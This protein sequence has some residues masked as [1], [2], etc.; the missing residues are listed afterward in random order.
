MFI[1]SQ[2]SMIKQV[3]RSLQ[4]GAII[5]LSFLLGLL[6]GSTFVWDRKNGARQEKLEARQI[7]MESL[8]RARAKKIRTENFRKMNR[9]TKRLSPKA[10]K[11]PTGLSQT[12]IRL[13]CRIPQVPS[14]DMVRQNIFSKNIGKGRARDWV[15]L[16]SRKLISQI[17][18]FWDGNYSNPTRF[19]R[20]QPDS[21][22]VQSGMGF[23]HLVTPASPTR[24]R[25]KAMQYGLV[26][27]LKFR[28]WGIEDSFVG[29]ASSIF[30]LHRD[31]WKDLPGAD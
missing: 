1:V 13:K 12:L 30:Y 25:K 7:Y 24:M 27:S 4:P 23:S 5:L 15:V 16:C 26:K 22:Y 19:E 18:I 6:L 3:F 14:I 11:L 17:F 20:S 31:K 2:A 28:H 29:K 21:H 9:E 8:E 10:F